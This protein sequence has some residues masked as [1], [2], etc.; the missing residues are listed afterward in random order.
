M[1]D[2]TPKLSPQIELRLRQELEH[3]L[4][5]EQKAKAANTIKRYQSA[6]KLYHAYTDEL[7][8]AAIP[9]NVAV[10]YAFFSYLHK[11][12]YALSTIFIIKSAIEYEHK[13]VNV[14]APTNHPR[15]ENL[16]E[17]IRR[18][19]ANQ[20]N[21]SLPVCFDE[22]KQI[23]NHIDLNHLGDY[24]DKSMILMGFSC[25][26]RPSELVNLKYTDLKFVP[27]GLE[28][29]LAQSKVDQYAKGHLVAVPYNLKNPTYCPILA[30]KDWIK[31][32]ALDD[33]S[34]FRGLYKGNKKVRS[35]AISYQGYF[36]L[37]KKRCF[38]AGLMTDMISPHGLRSGFNTSAANAGAKLHKMREIT[39]QSLLT[40]QRYI[41][42]TKLFEDNAIEKI[43][44]KD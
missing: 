10:L 41:K 20:S 7:N 27:E 28:V 26:F 37:F 9:G 6:L 11:E 15:I 30:I 39:N 3:A 33:G 29:L 23:I 35:T 22:V 40:Q 32:A 16:L 31:N 14:A 13:K 42:K 17:G 24:R 4:A 21:G 36:D 19:L 38:N 18:D 8:V 34:L 25:G 44:K 5:L 1:P 2:L 12:N 43:F